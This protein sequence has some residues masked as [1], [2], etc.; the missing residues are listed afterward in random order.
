MACVRVLLLRFL[1]GL[2]TS[3]DA[4]DATPDGVSACRIFTALGRAENPYR[5]GAGRDPHHANQNLYEFVV[6][7]TPVCF[8]QTWAR[9]VWQRTCEPRRVL[10]VDDDRP[11]AISW[12]ARSPNTDSHSSR[13]RCPRGSL[14][15]QRRSPRD[16]LDVH[17]PDIRL[18][19]LR[20][21]EMTRRDA[22]HHRALGE[23]KESL[24]SRR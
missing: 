16:P 11:S 5:W 10:V 22:I 23:R 17:L 9:S 3:T 21:S 18:S 13:V 24:R 4:M 12:R 8:L 6:E 14:S 1:V 7:A 19:A 15:I 20:R 2:P